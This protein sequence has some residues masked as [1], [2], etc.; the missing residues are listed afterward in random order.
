MRKVALRIDDAQLGT[1]DLRSLVVIL[2]LAVFAFRTWQQLQALRSSPVVLPVYSRYLRA[3]A[4][5]SK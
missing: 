1:G 3:P 5:P 4:R 2:V